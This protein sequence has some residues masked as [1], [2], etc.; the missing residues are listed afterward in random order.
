MPIKIENVENIRARVRFVQDADPV[1]GWT[2][3]AHVQVG[4]EN[5]S[6]GNGLGSDHPLD[7]FQIH[8]QL[9]S[10]QHED[11]MHVYGWCVRFIHV[12]TVEERECKFMYDFIHKVNGEMTKLY[13]RFGNPQTY[14]QYVVRVL[15]VLGICEVVVE[16]PMHHPEHL[17]RSDL[18][19]YTERPGLIYCID[20]RCG[21]KIADWHGQ[22]WSADR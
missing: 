2:R 18:I 6:N 7:H 20:S 16:S 21:E 19:H 4:F 15:D 1:P 12:F 17:V 10:G 13:N 9:D 5:R 3:Y 14:G 11:P 22:R 8:S